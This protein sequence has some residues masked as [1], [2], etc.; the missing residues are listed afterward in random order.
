MNQI[1]KRK[2]SQGSFKQKKKITKKRDRKK[3]ENMGL[4]EIMSHQTKNDEKK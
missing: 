4:K 3:K 2:G 1:R